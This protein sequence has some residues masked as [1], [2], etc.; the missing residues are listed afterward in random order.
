MSV[1]EQILSIKNPIELHQSL[2][3]YITDHPNEKEHI[4]RVMDKTAHHLTFWE[5]NLGEPFETNPN[6][7]TDIYF[8]NLQI[9][10]VNNF[11]KEKFLHTLDVA[12]YLDQHQSQFLS[13]SENERI[14]LYGNT[15]GII[16]V[17]G[18]A[19]FIVAVILIVFYFKN[20]Y[21]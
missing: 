7:W 12:S 6:K 4:L 18:V 16:M 13:E 14:K 8:R 1:L 3:R 19:V 20:K 17:A 21:V 9:Q 11:S 2:V 5:E 10:L 15:M